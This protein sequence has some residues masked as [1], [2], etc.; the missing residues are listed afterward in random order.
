MEHGPVATLYFICGADQKQHRA[1]SWSPCASKKGLQ[2]V[3]QDLYCL[4]LYY[5]HAD[6]RKMAAVVVAA[7]AVDT[8]PVVCQSL[9]QVHHVPLTT[10]LYPLVTYILLCITHGHCNNTT[11]S[12][13]VAE[14]TFGYNNTF[15]SARYEQYL[16]TNKT[17]SA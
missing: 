12:A 6:D 4:C 16:C 14:F 2:I 8:K 15:F 7:A 3:N 5:W 10:A 1:Q 17:A 11:N 9:S 13:L